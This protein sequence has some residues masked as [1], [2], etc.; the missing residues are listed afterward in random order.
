MSS[1]PP[2]AQDQAASIPERGGALR[3]FTLIELLVV[4]AIIGLVVA[5]LLPAL[6]KAR[7]CTI[8][9]REM[10]AAQQLIPAYT[11]YADDHRGALLPGYAPATMVVANPPAGIRQIEVFDETGERLYGV[12]AQRYP[13]R[14]APYLNYDMAALY[15]DAKVLS[16][17]RSRSDYQ[18]IISLSPTF[19]INGDFVGGRA[20]PG[21][22]FSQAALNA[23]GPFYVTR[24]DQPRHPD[25]LLAFASSRGVD[26]DAGDP[27]E[28]YYEV[29]SPNFTARRWTVAAGAR[30]DSESAPPSSGFVH[31]RHEGA[32][33]VANLDGHVATLTLAELED[34]RRW[35]NQARR[36]DWFVGQP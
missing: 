20:A 10:A 17:Y 21:Y 8:R 29:L 24:I 3:A 6:G 13:W 7:R 19:G 25:M 22:G 35:S 9:V 2:G 18:Y 34:M 36:P 33:V 1:T 14:L 27:V 15:K 23:W 32:A 12:L 28:G 30:F 26:P 5:I 4:I 31:P 16:R 11:S